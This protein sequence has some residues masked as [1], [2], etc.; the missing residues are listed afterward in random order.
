M[1]IVG[2]VV[3]D[4]M[5]RVLGPVTV[6][7]R[8]RFGRRGLMTSTEAARSSGTGTIQGS[9]LLAGGMST[10]WHAHVWMRS[11]VSIQ[12]NVKLHKV[13]F[14][15]VGYLWPVSGFADVSRLEHRVLSFS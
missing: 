4:R 3:E 14:S 13:F 8:L 7:A 15:I 10:L 11:M 1:E 2:R 9:G 12:G 6:A 5:R